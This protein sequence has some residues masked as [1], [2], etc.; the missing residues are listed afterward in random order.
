MVEVVVAVV[1]VVMF[2]RWK[3][4]EPFSGESRQEKALEILKLE[5]GTQSKMN[6]TVARVGKGVPTAHSPAAW[7][8]LYACSAAG[9]D[10]GE[11]SLLGKQ[12]DELLSGGLNNCDTKL[13]QDPRGRAVPPVR[14]RRDRLVSRRASLSITPTS[15]LQAYQ[16]VETCCPVHTVMP[17][18]CS[19]LEASPRVAQRPLHRLV[20]IRLCPRAYN[21]PFVYLVM[22]GVATLLYLHHIIDGDFMITW[23]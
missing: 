23:K 8:P 17:S 12:A 15:D 13:T 3:S 4:G 19:T 10:E 1:A 22:H 20:V 7:L 6:G 21:L 14:S 16:N 18:T 11:T 2:S 5:Q 9:W